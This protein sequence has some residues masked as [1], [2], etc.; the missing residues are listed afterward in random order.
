M[1]LDPAAARA[2]TNTK[3]KEIQTP[4]TTNNI[5]IIPAPFFVPEGTFPFFAEALSGVNHSV[6]REMFQDGGTLRSR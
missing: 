2:N 3:A 5:F 6:L 4:P 1:D